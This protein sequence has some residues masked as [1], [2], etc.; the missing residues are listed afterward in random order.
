[1]PDGI[2]RVHRDGSRPP[3]TMSAA[4]ATRLR[5]AIVAVAPA[6]LFAALVWHPYLAGPYRMKRR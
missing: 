5:A 4:M 2:L 6:A 1:M 3:T